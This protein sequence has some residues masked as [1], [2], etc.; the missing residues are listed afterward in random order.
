M[1]IDYTPIYSPDAVDPIILERS[2][3]SLYIPL[4]SPEPSPIEM[5]WKVLK[6][7][8]RRGEVTNPETLSKVIEY[9]ED[10]PVERIQNFI[11]ALD[12][13]IP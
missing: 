11:Q 9:S 1:P 10:V 4:D 2:Y 7:R 3:I 12:R 6:G 8:V 5:F 13:C